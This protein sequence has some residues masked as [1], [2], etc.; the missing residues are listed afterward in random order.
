MSDFTL[1]QKIDIHVHVNSINTAF[2]EQARVDNF[3]LL[4]INVAYP[5]FPPLEEQQ[6]IAVALMKT[7]PELIT[8]AS[9]FPMT[10]WDE[11]DWAERTIY[12]LDKTFTK[13][14]IAVKVWKNI[15]MEFR[16]KNYKLVMIDDPGF[17]SILLHL[18]EKK[19]PLIGHLGEPKNCW[20]PVDSMTVNTDKE[21]YR[22]HP[23]YH[24][25]KHPELPSYEE[26]L[27]VRDRMLEKNTELQFLASHLA[28]LEW[29]VDEVAKFLDKFPAVSVDLA[30]RMGHLQYQSRYNREKVR[31]FFIRYQDRILYATDLTVAPEAN[32]E[33][34]ARAAH[35]K[36]LEDWNYL[37]SDFTMQVPELDEPVKGL[38]LPKEVVEKIYRLNAEKLFPSAWKEN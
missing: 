23:Q 25:F 30:E 31:E 29:N 17:D 16:D 32:P 38:T 3:K 7:F 26:Q 21:Y 5:G 34:C 33:E 18:R 1:L 11:P 10:G 4:T 28:S 24:M 27:A 15:G 36:W 19:I 12:D 20:L 22:Q 2:L 8:Y 35:K 13:G 6:E 14:A 9:T 37:N